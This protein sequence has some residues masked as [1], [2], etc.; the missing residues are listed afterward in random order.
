MPITGPNNKY[1]IAPDNYS[2]FVIINDFVFRPKQVESFYRQEAVDGL[3]TTTVIFPP[4]KQTVPDPEWRLYSFL[5]KRKH[6]MDV[7]DFLP[8]EETL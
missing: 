2:D 7:K 1:S 8:P 4:Y 5:L 6:P 3:R